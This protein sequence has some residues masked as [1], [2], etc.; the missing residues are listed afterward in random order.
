MIISN[1]CIL[2]LAVAFLLVASVR[3]VYFTIKTD[4]MTKDNINALITILFLLL[5]AAVLPRLWILLF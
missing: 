2:I 4:K 1:V 5:A 3:S